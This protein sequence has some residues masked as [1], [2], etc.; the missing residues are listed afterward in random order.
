MLARLVYPVQVKEGHTTLTDLVHIPKEMG[1][2]RNDQLVG[3]SAEIVCELGGRVCYD[4]LGTGRS[5]KE[6]HPNIIRDGFW[7]IYEHAHFTVSLP[8]TNGWFLTCLLN[9]PDLYVNVITGPLQSNLRVTANLRHVLEWHRKPG[10]GTKEANG[11]AKIMGQVL[12]WHGMTIAPQV[13]GCLPPSDPRTYEPFIKESR[14]EEPMNDHERFITMYMEG[15]RVWSHEMVRHR[16]NM[17]QR[18]GRYCDES[19]TPYVIHPL[20]QAWLAGI[21]LRKLNICEG[22]AKDCYSIIVKGVQGML[23]AKGVDKATA[24][25]QARSAGRYYLGNGLQTAMI[26][27]ASVA[28]W[29]GIFELRLSKHA[30]AEIR[31][32]MAQAFKEAKRSRW[33]DSFSD[34]NVLDTD[35]GPVLNY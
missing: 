28:R 9:R 12:A 31:T 20:T 8:I 4:S 26:Y 7:S 2:Q 6:Y 11:A 22:E 27:T 1:E 23:E 21:D 3:T 14:L 10:N 32:I 13:V 35:T 17:S 34:M 30:D 5:T 15:S 18:S 24:R 33:A 29:R 19:E 16:N 25:K